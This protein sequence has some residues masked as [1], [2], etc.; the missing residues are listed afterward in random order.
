M[1]RNK[2]ADLEV[3]HEKNMERKTAAGHFEEMEAAGAKK[4][5]ETRS[6]LREDAEK[7]ATCMI[8]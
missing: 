7:L 5:W 1:E 4:L 6:E 3:E 2:I 8:F